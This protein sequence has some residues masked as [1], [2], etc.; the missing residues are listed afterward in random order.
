MSD[1]D[2]G[3]MR[4]GGTLVAPGDKRLD[5]V[6]LTFHHAFNIAVETV[7]YPTR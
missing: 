2:R 7:T 6:L 3:D 1:Q 5:S 4:P